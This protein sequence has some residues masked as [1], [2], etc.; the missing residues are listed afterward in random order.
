M[1]D[2]TIIDGV[3][4][5]GCNM[6]RADGYC[7]LFYAELQSD[8]DEL[9][10]GP[11]CADNPNC[12]YKQLARKTKVIDALKKAVI[13]KENNRYV[14]TC[15]LARKT[16]E[17]ERLKMQYN[18]SACGDCNGKED[19]KNMKRHIESALRQLQAEKQKAEGLQKDNKELKERVKELVEDCD[20]CLYYIFYRN[21][22]LLKNE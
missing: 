9:E 5:S 19:Y 2:K 7:D 13:L 11:N 1:T 17:C 22:R 3:D 4:V 21:A 15:L 18:C 16:E 6:R 8:K 10:Y 12:H 20:S 14:Q